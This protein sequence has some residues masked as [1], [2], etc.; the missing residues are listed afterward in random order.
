VASGASA[1]TA[2]TDLY[3][4]GG[5]QGAAAATASAD[6]ASAASAT[7]GDASFENYFGKGSATGSLAADASATGASTAEAVIDGF[8]GF[9]YDK[10]VG[11]AQV[12]ATASD[13]S[14][15]HA[16][17][18]RAQPLRSRRRT[19]WLGV[20]TWR[21]LRPPRHA[22]RRP[23]CPLRLRR[24]MQPRRCRAAANQ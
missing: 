20:C 18:S 8:L 4:D 10:S 21:A 6:G 11:N 3:V 24:G 23:C 16:E 12:T 22:L 5:S 19:P 17:A 13:E 2:T 14:H 15:A 1:A 7:I 9:A